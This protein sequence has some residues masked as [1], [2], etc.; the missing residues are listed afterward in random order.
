MTLLPSN[1]LGAMVETQML[2]VVLFAVILGVA[3]LTLPPKQAM[4]LLG[5]LESTQDVCMTI[6]GWAMALAPFAVF[7]LIAQLV[8]Q[9]GVGVLVGV[10]AY[11]GCVIGGLLILLGFYLVAVL[12]LARRSPRAF[13][14]AAREVQLLAF[15]TSSSAAVM[16]LSIRTAEDKLGVRPSVAQL[17]VPLGA[18]INMDGTALYQGVATLFLAQVFGVDIGLF[19][20]AAVVVTAVGAS[21]GAPGT[22]GVGIVL[23]AMILESAGVPAAGIALL[24]GVDRL[25]DMARTALNVTGDLTACVVMDRLV[26]ADPA[27]AP[28]TDATDGAPLIEPNG[29]AGV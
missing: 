3:L 20:L 12:V 9:T 26:A 6:V 1:P 11:V 22:P 4:P 14:V 28:T 13:L 10:A 23:L 8:M 24:L 2:Q 15:S 5:F 7:G 18:T 16:P 17:V 21:V 27:P 29:A 19:G 25:L